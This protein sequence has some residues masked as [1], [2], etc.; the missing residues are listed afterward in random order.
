MGIPAVYA[1]ETSFE[2]AVET[3]HAVL[4]GPFN[5]VD[6]SNGYGDSE[7]Q[8]GRAITERGGLPDD[9]LLATKVDPA[10]GSSDFSGDRVRQ[11]V[12]ESRERLG[13][14]QL[15]LVH[16]HDPERVPFDEAM[17]PGGAVETLLELKQ[18]GVIGHL[19]VAG[20]DGSLLQRY[21]ETG[22]FDVLLIHNQFTLIDQSA[23]ALFDT[24]VELGVA[25]LNAAPYGGGM[26]A[27]GPDAVPLYCY[28]IDREEIRER[29]RAMQ[30]ACRNAEVPLAAA[31]LQFSLR[32]PRITSTVVGVS[33]PERVQA[34]ADLAAW[35]IPEHLWE[36]LGPHMQPGRVRASAGSSPGWRPG[37]PTDDVAS[38]LR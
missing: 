35:P 23:G 20:F 14:D 4:S 34:T 26:L 25:V 10:P 21:L 30:S 17:G 2:Q 3:M 16:F 22:V 8:I 5:F 38:Y 33:R 1:A 11:S 36:E 18:E 9:L 32:D 7:R 12:A 28:G 15:P 6:T 31:A 37:F 13:M 29:A 27:K 19:G 24:A